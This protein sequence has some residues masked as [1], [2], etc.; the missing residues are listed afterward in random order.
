MTQLTF[1]ICKARYQRRLLASGGQW[2]W[3]V[4]FLLCPPQW[5]GSN[6]HWW[7]PDC[8]SKFTADGMVWKPPIFLCHHQDSKRHHDNPPQDLWFDFPSSHSFALL[9]CHLRYT[10]NLKR[11]D[12]IIIFFFWTSFLH[13]WPLNVLGWS[14]FHLFVYSVLKPTNWIVYMW[15]SLQHIILYVYIQ[16]VSLNMKLV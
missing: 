14:F 12:T 8:G 4:E 16:L 11:C 15:K 5:N 3:H 1:Q 6:K 2:W 7:H 9:V 10:I 13:A